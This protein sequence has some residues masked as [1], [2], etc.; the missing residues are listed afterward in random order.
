MVAGCCRV[1]FCYLLQQFIVHILQ[2][3]FVIKMSLIKLR[4]NIGEILDSS[5]NFLIENF[6]EFVR[7]IAHRN[8]QLL[9]M[10]D[11]EPIFLFLGK[12]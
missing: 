7:R 11:R 10:T 1:I 4:N 3:N 6:I 5:A 2:L 9:K 8:F 12:S